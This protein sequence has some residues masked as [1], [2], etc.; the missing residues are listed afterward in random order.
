MSRSRE[1]LAL[2]PARG[3]SKSIPRKN[4]RLV[5]GKSLIA[6]SIEHA[7]GS[8]VITRVMVSTEDPEIAQVAKQWRAEVPFF[9]PVELAADETP[10]L[11]VFQHALNWL[12][13]HERY[14]PDVV[15]H[16]R[17]TAPIRRVETI[18][19]AI[20]TFLA[21]PD[22]DSLRSVS[23][24]SQNPYKM[25]VIA[26]DGYLEPVVR[27]ADG[28]ESWNQPR[29]SLPRAYWQ[30]SYL[31]LTRPTVILRVGSMTGRHILPF[32]VD[33]PCVEI[34]YAD[35]LALAKRLLE[36]SQPHAPEAIP[37]AERFPS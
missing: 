22:A 7:R 27:L 11:P 5:A 12:H 33:E 24:A 23:L 21:H 2:I 18:D 32:V 1:I 25:W 15:V 4:L 31:D 3:G 17:P 28:R 16:L 29:Q 14:V 6:H 36:D 9:R 20:R 37:S 13:Q 34:D 26:S 35:Q 8:H 10:D 19:R 30:N